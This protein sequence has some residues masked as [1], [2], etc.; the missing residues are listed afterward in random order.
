MKEAFDTI[1]AGITKTNQNGVKIQTILK[2]YVERNYDTNRFD[3]DDPDYWTNKEIEE[4]E[5]EVYQYELFESGTITLVPETENPYDSNAIMVW[6]KDMGKIGYVPRDDNINLTNFINY[7]FDNIKVDMELESGPYKYYDLS[8]GKVKKK[9]NPFYLRLYVKPLIHSSEITD[10][11]SP[12]KSPTP[13]VEEKSIDNNLNYDIFEWLAKSNY[14]DLYI[15]TSL[16]K[17]VL[18]TEESSEH[19]K[20]ITYEDDNKYKNPLLYLAG[21]IIFTI[22]AIIFIVT[23]HYIIMFLPILLAIIFSILYIESKNKKKDQS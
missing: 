5:F 8:T 9:N 3:K 23:D 1:V 18:N 11:T 20:N 6:H 2:M 22:L 17:P 21:S 10:T 7:D 12:A 16:Q 4:F 14:P 13:E 15:R 19:S